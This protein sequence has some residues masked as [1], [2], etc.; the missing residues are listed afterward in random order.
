MVL[1]DVGGLGC[2]RSYSN[3]IHTK[4]GLILADTVQRNLERQSLYKILIGGIV[5]GC[6][7]SV[8]TLYYLHF[9]CDVRVENIKRQ[10]T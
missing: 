5:V 8:G 1:E 2:S 6:K 9:V 7:Y 4:T 10:V 3:V